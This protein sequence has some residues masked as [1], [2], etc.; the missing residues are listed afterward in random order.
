MMTMCV[1]ETTRSPRP[2]QSR[3]RVVSI[4]VEAGNKSLRLWKMTLTKRWK[5]NMFTTR[6]KPKLLT[7]AQRMFHKSQHRPQKVV[8]LI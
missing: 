3:S 2:H 1:D 8:L 6:V 7:P 5:E 4:V